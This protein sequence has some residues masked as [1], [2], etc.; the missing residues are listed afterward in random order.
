MQRLKGE[1]IANFNNISEGGEDFIAIKLMLKG[2]E[3]L[4]SIWKGMSC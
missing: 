3:S 2:K 4:G 1:I